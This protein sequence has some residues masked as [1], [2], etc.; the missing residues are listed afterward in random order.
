MAVPSLTTAVPPRTPTGRVRRSPRISSV[1]LKAVMA[2]TGLALFGFVVAHMVGNL[3][4]FFGAES[5]DSY[6][7]FLRTVGE[8]LIP[9]RGLLWIMRIGLLVAVFA[10]IIAAT[11]LARRARRARPVRYHHRSKVQGSYAARTMRWGGVIIALFVLYHLMDLTLLW[12][13]PH[14][15]HG[16]AYN[17]VTSDFQRWPVVLVYTLAVLTLG[18]HLRHG[19]WSALRSL[20]RGRARTEARLRLIALTVAV[21]ICA[22]YLSVPFAVLT[23]LVS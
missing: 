13:N 8:P 15:V 5:F 20:G 19:V 12:L 6:A 22:G 3:K 10:H 2:V 23:G 14:G 9:E 17:N 7:R 1:I 11:M 18:F 21:L 16:E 4:I